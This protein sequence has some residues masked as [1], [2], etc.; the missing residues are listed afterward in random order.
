MAKLLYIESSPRKERSKSIT[1]AR[2]FIAAYQA[3]HPGDEVVTLDLWQKKLPEFDGY[4]IDAKYQVLHGQSFDKDQQAAW[5]A[6][7]DV[8]DEFKSADKYLFSLPMWNFGIPYKLK[9]YIDVL[10]QPGQT[11][12]FDPATGYSGLVTGKPAVVIYARGGAY[13][14]DATKGLDLQKGYLDLLL[15]FIGFKD[16]KSILIEPT[17]AAPADVSK[18]EAA[19]IAEAKNL[20]AAT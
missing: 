15:G 8:C 7:V 2:A 19:A 17:L 11:F 6:V 1:V 16:I 13:G 4:T 20:A 5:Q 12:S 14:S 3:K 10:A 18:T 9:H